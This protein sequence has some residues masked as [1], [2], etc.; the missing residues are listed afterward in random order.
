MSGCRGGGVFP[1]HLAE[2]QQASLREGP[3]SGV[4]VTLLTP[5]LGSPFAPAPCTSSAMA[6]PSVSRLRHCKVKSA[7]DSG[8]LAAAGRG[9]VSW[10]GVKVRARWGPHCEP[11]GPS[12]WC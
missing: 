9:H 5:R 11:W 4:S 6:N 10:E 7:F 8:I 2:P 3:G 1:L 12:V